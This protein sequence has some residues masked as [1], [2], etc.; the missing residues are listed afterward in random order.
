MSADSISVVVVENQPLMLTALSTAL[1][2]AGMN[3]LAEVSQSGQVIQTVQRCQPQM[4]LFSASGIPDMERISVLRHEFPAVTILALVNGDYR[5][6]ERLALDFG[7][8]AA[9]SKTASR[10]KLVKM[11]KE[12]LGQPEFKQTSMVGN[13]LLVRTPAPSIY[14]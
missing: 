3:V 12:L 6:Q 11:L 7:A 10:A 5:G 4:V 14:S 2:V 1:S 9:L 13:P 8:H